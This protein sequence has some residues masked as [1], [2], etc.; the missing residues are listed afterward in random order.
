[1]FWSGIGKANWMEIMSSFGCL[2]SSIPGIF[3]LSGVI[4]RGI[5]FFSRIFFSFF[6]LA[7]SWNFVV[8][9][10]IQVGVGAGF[11]CGFILF[12][13][14]LFY[15]VFLVNSTFPLSLQFGSRCTVLFY[16]FTFFLFS[17]FFSVVF[18]W[19]FLYLVGHDP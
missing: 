7:F 12:S 16:F 9:R 19:A 17:F 4:L 10:G 5:L 13:P 18:P 3:S 11:L 1:M 14:H 2:V 15:I 8:F 6:S